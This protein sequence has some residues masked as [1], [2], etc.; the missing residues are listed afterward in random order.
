MDYLGLFCLGA[1]VGTLATFGLRRVQS[2]A[3]WPTRVSV[4]IKHLERDA[5]APYSPPQ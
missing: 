5:L 2:V 3:E 4:L 1:F